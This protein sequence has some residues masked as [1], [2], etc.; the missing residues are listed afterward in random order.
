VADVVKDHEWFI[1]AQSITIIH[2][3]LGNAVLLVLKNA[4]HRWVESAW[5]LYY[6]CNFL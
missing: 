2:I 6:C 3:P 1:R 5:P 4:F